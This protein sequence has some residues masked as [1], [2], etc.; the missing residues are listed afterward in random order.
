MLNAETPRTSSC[1]RAQRVSHENGA[2]RRSG[3]RES[4]SGSPRGEAP[5]MRIEER[6]EGGNVGL[7]RRARE[8]K[9]DSESDANA[10]LHAPAAEVQLRAEEAFV[11]RHVGDDLLPRELA[12]D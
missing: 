10:E 6:A 12:P 2:R 7:Y 4:V 3:A 8:L 9:A 5:R 1:E 11:D